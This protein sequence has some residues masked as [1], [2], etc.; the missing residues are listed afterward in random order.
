MNWDGLV[1][2]VT[3]ASSG[4]GRAAAQAFANRG[5]TVIA[6]ARREDRLAELV[7]ELGGQPHSYVVCDLSDIGQIRGM[8]QTIASR[9]PKVDVLLNNAGIPGPGL[10]TESTPEE[11]EAFFKVNLLAPIWCIQELFPL[12][13]HAPR[14]GRTPVI[15]NLASMAGRIPVPS[16][17]P[18]TASKY[19][20]VG[21]TESLWSE[22][23][24]KGI[25]VMVVNPGFVHTEGFPMDP[26]LKNPLL[27]WTVMKAPRVA[28]AVC[29]GIESGS[30]EVR[31]Q[32]WWHAGYYATILLGPLRR[33]VSQAVWGSMNSGSRGRSR[34]R[35]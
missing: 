22:M 10:V 19:A 17:A 21:F 18:Y 24:G 26:L 13:A 31:V 1:C 25:Q 28:E 2:V 30:T 5:A 32:G 4:I 7:E 12:L 8:A 14:D 16:S 20:L 27:R 29:H 3:G 11:I 15:V 35:I 23:H 34:V 6:V 33:R 9:T